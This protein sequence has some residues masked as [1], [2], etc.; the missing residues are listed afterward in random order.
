MLSIKEMQ[1]LISHG[2]SIHGA[3]SNGELLTDNDI[4]VFDK[5]DKG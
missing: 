4:T 3:G 2:A 5:G 1:S